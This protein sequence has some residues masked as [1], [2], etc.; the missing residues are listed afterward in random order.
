MIV[1]ID[2]DNTYSAD[3]STFDKIIVLFKQAGHTVICVT[4]RSAAMGQPVLNS[5]GKLV[6]VIFAGADWKRD[7]A[8]KRAYKVDVW[9]DDTPSSIEKQILIGR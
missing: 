3:P 5:I 9:I 7:A 6:P 2:Y 4:G 8:A 1:A